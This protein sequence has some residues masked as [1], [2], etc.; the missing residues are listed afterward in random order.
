M[1]LIAQRPWLHFTLVQYIDTLADSLQDLVMR[2]LLW[3]HVWR[4]EIQLA[5]P[6]Q[7]GIVFRGSSLRLFR[8]WRDF[9]WSSEKLRIVPSDT[10]RVLFSSNEWKVVTQDPK[11]H[12]AEIL[13]CKLTFQ[14]GYELQQ[15]ERYTVWNAIRYPHKIPTSNMSSM[16]LS[17][18]FSLWLTRQVVDSFSRNN[19][20]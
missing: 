2:E 10:R 5:S 1:S 7:P 20:Y 11:L 8:R 9:S 15:Q 3:P 6:R 18:S 4:L 16:V 13:V 12:R 19:Q 14:A 17:L